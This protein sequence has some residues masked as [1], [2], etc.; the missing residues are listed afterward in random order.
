MKRIVPLKIIIILF[1]L[2]LSLFF[3]FKKK[4]NDKTF[5]LHSEKKI[6]CN[7]IACRLKSDKLRRIPKYILLMDYYK[8]PYCNDLNAYYIFKY[9]QKNNNQNA[10]YIINFKSDLYK[11]LAKQ[12]RTQNLLPVNSND[13]I[14]NK[15]YTL[16]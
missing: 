5:I 12:N 15:L 6:R 13:N 10:Y 16:F 11:N 1:N 14:F 3:F 4:N 2:F 7:S 9:Y 8:N